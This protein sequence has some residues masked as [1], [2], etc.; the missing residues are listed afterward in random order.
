MN[1]GDQ[2]RKGSDEVR[3]IRARTRLMRAR[4]LA[5]LRRV[6]I[7]E[8]AKCSLPDQ[9]ICFVPYRILMG[10][11]RHAKKLA[12]RFDERNRSNLRPI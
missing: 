5:I 7:V 12:H 8:Q 9:P 4:V 11:F 3:H 6:D 1:D 2:K 10:V